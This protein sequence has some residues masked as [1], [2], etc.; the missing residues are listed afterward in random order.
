MSDLRLAVRSLRATPVVTSVALLS[1][2]LGIGANTAIFSLV[3]TTPCRHLVG[4]L[5]RAGAAPRGA[6]ALR[7]HGVRSQPA[8]NGDCSETRE[9]ADCR[10]QIAFYNLKSQSE[11]CNLRSAISG[12]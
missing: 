2:A 6:R 11:F 8:A 4:F 9:I 1:L 12:G 3:D 7:R 10:L 5:R